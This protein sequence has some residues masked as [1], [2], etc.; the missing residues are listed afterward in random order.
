MSAG[1]VEIGCF[2]TYSD[3]YIKAAE[4]KMSQGGGQGSDVSVPIDKIKELGSHYHKYH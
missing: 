3:D 1:K 4:A 2:R